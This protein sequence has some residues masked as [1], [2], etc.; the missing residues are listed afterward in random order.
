MKDAFSFTNRPRLGQA[1]DGLGFKAKD[2]TGFI[3]LLR[4]GVVFQKPVRSYL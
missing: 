3:T 2:L 4:F 1:K